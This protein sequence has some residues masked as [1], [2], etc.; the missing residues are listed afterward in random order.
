[1]GA[2]G[3]WGPTSAPRVPMGGMGAPGDPK[4]GQV[5]PKW[6]HGGPKW[7]HGGPKCLQIRVWRSPPDGGTVAPNQPQVSP[8]GGWWP[9]ESPDGDMVTPNRNMVTP[10]GDMVAPS[11]SRLGYGDPKWGA[12]APH[13]PQVS[14]WGGWGHQE[15]P[16]GGRLS[17]NGDTVA[18]S[19]I[20]WGVVTPNGELWA[21]IC[22]K[23]PPVGG[24]GPQVS[25]DGGW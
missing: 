25:P 4:W 22:P 24:W 14:P 9:Q 7:G 10:N 15:T 20:R 21:H 18:L 17:P 11:V 13:L 16:N 5:E 12:V 3:S 1:M 19:V 2:N 23:C 8:W 6:G